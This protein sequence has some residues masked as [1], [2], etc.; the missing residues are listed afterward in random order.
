MSLRYQNKNLRHAAAFALSAVALTAQAHAKVGTVCLELPAGA[1]MVKAEIASGCLPTSPQ[2]DGAFT[3]VVD[4][5]RAVIAIDGSFKPTREQR[6]STADCMGSR[7]IEQESEAAGPRRYSVMV[8]GE[9]RGV[10][11]AS[12]T[13]FGMRA[14]KDCFAGSGRVQQRR[15]EVIV[16]YNPASFKDWIGQSKGKPSN[17]LYTNTYAAPAQAA[18]ALI[19]NHP[20][21]KEGRP[22]AQITIS[23]AR[24]R[25]GGFPRPPI[26][27]FMAIQIEEHGY[28]DDSVSG[29]RTFAAVKQDPTTGEW[30]IG[31]HWHQFMCARGERAGQ[32]SAQ[33]CL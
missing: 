19:G 11:D 7:T 13:Q 25:F 1:G 5:Q 31:R 18:A 2:Y 6:V 29:K 8:N 32:W 33:P 10:L 24:W 28:L 17:P 27:Y 4:A 23:K 16:S 22:S 30:R 21:S 20:Q 14:V 3:V 12:D 26:P 15:P 9:Y